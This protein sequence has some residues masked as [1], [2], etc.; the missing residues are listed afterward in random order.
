MAASIDFYFDFASPYG[1]F[2]SHRIDELAAK[3]GRAVAWRP[4]LLGAAFK[5]TGAKP[6]S[7]QSPIRADYFAHDW[8][9][10]AR[11]FKVPFRIPEGFPHAAV[12]SSRAFYWL[13]DRD[14]TMAKA[15]ARRIYGAYFGEGR[16]FT[17]AEMVAGE[18]AALGVDRTELLPALQDPA[19][20][21]R[22][23]REVDAAIGRGVFGSP[24]FFVD[25]EMFWGHDRLEEV[26]EWL[27]RGGW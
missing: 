13:D 26:E 27:E 6:L 14:P 19:V 15:F 9:R 20:K 21:D 17:S 18:A 3:Y 11:R 23:K 7:Q 8:E 16:D 24:S 4:F 2:A 10:L 12:A 25:G 1:Y 22:L 5:L